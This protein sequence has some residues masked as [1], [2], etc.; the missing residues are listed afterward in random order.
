MYDVA[1]RAFLTFSK[2]KHTDLPLSDVLHPLSEGSLQ[3]GTELQ[4]I[5]ADLDDVVDKRAH[6]CQGKRG[7]EEHHVAKL[8]EHF[9]VVLKRV[10]FMKQHETK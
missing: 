8:N 1:W 3:A 4:G 9:L 7:G 2:T 6:G 10:L 5:A